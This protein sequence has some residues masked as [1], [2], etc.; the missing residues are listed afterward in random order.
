MLLNDTIL[1][2]N[3]G[4]I[5]YGQNIGGGCSQNIGDGGGCG[6]P[7]IGGGGSPIQRP[8]AAAAAAAIAVVS[9]TDEDQFDEDWEPK[10]T[11]AFGK[12][13]FSDSVNCLINKDFRPG[14]IKTSDPDQSRL[15]T[16]TLWLQ[17]LSIKISDPDKSK[18]LIRIN[19]DFKRFNY[20]F[21]PFQSRFQTRIN[22][23]F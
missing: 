2:V 22:Q 7:N 4:H 3:P 12:R 17:S 10:K 19:H 15:Q 13:E 1:R 14:L 21:N 18:L 11:S 9:D 23:D 5:C 8:A 20:D 6:G 16:D